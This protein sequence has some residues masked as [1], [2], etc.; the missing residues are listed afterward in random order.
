M[1]SIQQSAEVTNN[2]VFCLVQQKNKTKDKQLVYS[3]G[4]K[5]INLFKKSLA[6]TYL[7]AT[8]N[9]ES[10]GVTEWPALNDPVQDDKAG[11]EMEGM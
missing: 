3:G 6:G 1:G 2:K 11:T 5:Q 10:E 4:K 8:E 7:F 9:T